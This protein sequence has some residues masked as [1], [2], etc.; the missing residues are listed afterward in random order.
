VSIFSYLSLVR[1]LVGGRMEHQHHA[2]SVTG[3]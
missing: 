2:K 1:F 3:C